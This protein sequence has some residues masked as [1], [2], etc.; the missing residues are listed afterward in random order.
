MKKTTVLIDEQLL[1]DAMEAIGLKRNTYIVKVNNRKILKGLLQ[2]LG[3]D[4]EE[5]EQAVLRVI[6][7]TDKI[8]IDGLLEEL[9]KGRT[10]AS[11]A[12]IEGLQLADDTIK[13]IISFLNEFQEPNE[14]SVI[15]ERLYKYLGES[16][17]GKEGVDELSKINI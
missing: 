7:K 5:Q 8:G 10:D 3:I 9:G 15:V 14:R 17:V 13:A 1:T 2:N 16:E 11:G 6:D 12:K 4:T